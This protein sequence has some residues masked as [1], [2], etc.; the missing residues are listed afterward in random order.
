VQPVHAIFGWLQIERVLRVATDKF[1]PELARH[2]HAVPSE[3]VRNELK[4]MRN[5][6]NTLYVAR[7]RL[8][9]LPEVAGAGVF[10]KFDVA[11]IDD[12]RRLTYGDNGCSQWRLPSFFCSLSNMGEQPAPLNG[13]WYPQRRGPGQ[14]FVL[15]LEGREQEAEHWLTDIFKDLG[16]SPFKGAALIFQR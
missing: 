7:S 9:F 14:E 12:P 10:K 5:D 15:S 6:N 2:P 13:Y 16:E 11:K 1:P 4:A 8:S 3:L